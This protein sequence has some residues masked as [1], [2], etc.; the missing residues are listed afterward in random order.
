[1]SEGAERILERADECWFCEQSLTAL[2]ITK[3]RNENVYGKVKDHCHLESI[4][5]ECTKILKGLLI[6]TVILKLYNP[7]SIL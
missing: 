7:V 5:G 3:D 1:M 6:V 2:S 4:R